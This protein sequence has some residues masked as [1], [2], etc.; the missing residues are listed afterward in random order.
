[1]RALSRAAAIA[2]VLSL[3]GVGTAAAVP[4]GD[5]RYDMRSPELADWSGNIVTAASTHPTGLQGAGY[6][7]DNDPSTNGDSAFDGDRD[8]VYLQP[9]GRS[10]LVLHADSVDGDP[11][12]ATRDPV[13]C[14]PGSHLYFYDPSDAEWAEDIEVGHVIE[15]NLVFVCYTDDP[16]APVSHGYYVGYPENGPVT[17]ECVEFFNRGANYFQM[18]VGGGILTRDPVT[19]TPISQENCPATVYRITRTRNDDPATPQMDYEWEFHY[20]AD[21]DGPMQL[22]FTL[23]RF[24]H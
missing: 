22:R 6:L 15:G 9:S 10:S 23:H 24:E 7:L 14:Q 16:N 4:S 8:F 18:N 3:M 5:R 11:A 1:M 20:V 13:G 17:R 12:T 19:G 2:G 21:E